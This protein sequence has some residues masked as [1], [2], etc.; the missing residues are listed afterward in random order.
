MSLSFNYR[1]D[2]RVVANN[3]MSK[4]YAAKELLMVAAL[5]EYGMSLELSKEEIKVRCEVQVC[6]ALDPSAETL[7]IDGKPV[8]KTWT[9]MDPKTLEMSFKSQRLDK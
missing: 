6:M 2:P 5:A 8:L 1:P 3:W 9:E 7:L 4:T